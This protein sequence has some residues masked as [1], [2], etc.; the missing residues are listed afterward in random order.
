MLADRRQY[1]LSLRDAHRGQIAGPY[2]TVWA[3]NK[4]DRP[5]IKKMYRP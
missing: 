3:G 5:H 2:R 1:L 4:G